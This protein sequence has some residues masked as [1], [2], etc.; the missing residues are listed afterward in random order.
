MQISAKAKMMVQIIIAFILTSSCAE[1][2][3]N[4]RIPAMPVD[5][6]LGD[7][8]LWATYGIG[9]IG[10]YQIFDR[11]LGLPSNFHFLDKTYTGYGGVLLIG[12]SP[13]T[14]FPS[15]ET[16]AWPYQPAAFDLACPV[17]VDPSVKVAVDDMKLEAQCPMCS[18]RY[19]LEA[20]G[21]PVAGPALGMKYGLQRYTCSGSPL[22]GFRITN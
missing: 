11:N 21:A 14:A 10:V 16:Y 1:E 4:H 9:G 19:S 13:F 5:I 8:G 7:P 18:S 17:E 22:T 2:I 6:N 20:G 12:L 3:N 15:D